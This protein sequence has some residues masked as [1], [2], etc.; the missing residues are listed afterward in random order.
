MNI[1]GAI[2]YLIE[3]EG[4]IIPYGFD[5]GSK[6]GGTVIITNENQWNS[7]QW[8]PPEYL[9]DQYPN[10]DPNA[11][12]KP[13]WEKLLEAHK[14]SVFQFKLNEADLI[15]KHGAPHGQTIEFYKQEIIIDTGVKQ[16]LVEIA[17]NH[18]MDDYRKRLVKI[19][20]STKIVNERIKDAD[21]LI[22]YVNLYSTLLKSGVEA[23]IKQELI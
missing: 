12:P 13:T 3:N 10:S 1:S 5:P 7:Y 9:N 18:F 15:L 4:L 8:N 20:E 2:N 19:K 16:Q 17:H 21:S 14:E 11:S 22:R 6:V 23:L